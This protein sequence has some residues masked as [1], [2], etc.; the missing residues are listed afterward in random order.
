MLRAFIAKLRVFE[1]D[2]LVYEELHGIRSATRDVLSNSMSEENELLLFTH[3][4][5]PPTL[6]RSDNFLR[7]DTRAL[8]DES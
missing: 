8:N 5:L 2:A 7:V 3:R 1:E 4:I 6:P